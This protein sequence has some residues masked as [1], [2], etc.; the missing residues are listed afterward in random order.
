MVEK[1]WRMISSVMG[2]ANGITFH[3]A[4]WI[5][6]FKWTRWKK[7]RFRMQFHENTIEFKWIGEMR[8]QRLDSSDFFLCLL[9]ALHNVDRNAVKWHLKWLKSA[10][11][12]RLSIHG[13]ANAAMKFYSP[14]ECALIKMPTECA[15]DE[16]F[17]RIQNR[18][19]TIC[20]VKTVDKHEMRFVIIK[21][22]VIKRRERTHPQSMLML[23]H[24][25]LV[26][27]KLKCD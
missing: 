2:D 23:M 3:F 15:F 22:G 5:I 4:Q 11:F 16:T 1:A 18:S 19:E 25:W 13:Y 17:R 21:F 20:L 8:R 9:F 14:T 27:T 26:L 24:L 10:R 12:L 7:W 6:L